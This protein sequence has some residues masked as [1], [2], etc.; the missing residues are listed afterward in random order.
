MPSEAV[1]VPCPFLLPSLNPPTYLSPLANVNV[2]WQLVQPRNHIFGHWGR[3]L[4]AAAMVG[5]TTM[6]VSHV[7]KTAGAK[8]IDRSANITRLSSFL[9]L[10]PPPNFG[11]TQ[12]L[13][14]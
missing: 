7:A 2:P 3:R 11:A 14:S 10:E 8:D 5:T 6:P 12:A 4:W 9:C 13:K 1:S